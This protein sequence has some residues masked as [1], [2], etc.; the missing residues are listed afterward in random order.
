MEVHRGNEVE[1]GNEKS[2]EQTST[3]IDASNKDESTAAEAH[4]LL[5]D[6]Q[7]FEY[8]FQEAG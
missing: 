5:V 1:D 4:Q 8:K 6:H 7:Q 2:G 3:T